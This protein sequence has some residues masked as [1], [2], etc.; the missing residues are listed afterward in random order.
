MNNSIAYK[1]AQLPR[2]ALM[3]G[4]DPHKRTHALVV[5][6]ASGNVLVRF[7]VS[8]DRPGFDTALARCNEW[9]RHTGAAGCVF[10]IEAGA[11]YWRTIAYFLDE[12][13]QLFYLINPFTLK[14]QRDGNDLMR[15]KN[16][17]RDAE[18]A[19]Q[20]LREG[21][22]T[23]TALPRE[24]YAD[25]RTAHGTYQQLVLQ[26][27]QVKL[28]LIT[29]LDGLFPEFMTVFKAVD[30]QTALAV[31]TTC[32]NPATI[33]G[34]S[35]DEFVE[36]ISRTLGGR[37]LAAKKLQCLHQTASGTAGV[38][39]G[40]DAQAQRIE[41]LADRLAFL[42]MQRQ[43]AEDHLLD[44]FYQHSESQYLLS[45]HGLGAVNAAGI[46]AHIGDIRAYSSAKQLPKVAGIIPIESSSAGHMASRTPMSKKGRP[47]FRLILYRAV[48]G[49]VR[50]N[51]SIKHYVTR[52]TT[53]SVAAHPLKKK[54][55]VGAAM[56]KLL[57]I[58]YSLLTKRQMFDPALAAA[59]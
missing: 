1:V 25:L 32:P 51:E 36:C 41:L 16:D 21:K 34:M 38:R 8:T 20:L 49:L 18:M 39:A 7:Q 35:D 22:Y 13:K 57:R 52:L 48:I 9:C 55:A 17:Y 14:R 3:V 11:H 45:I 54:E 12:H 2:G 4:I 5:T 23:W 43:M 27:A 37:R 6:D 46:L 30:G 59:V 53:R 26:V 44:I 56:N 10:G 29:A 15:R 28:Q 42:Q 50:H 31:L 24:R 58:V 47:E 19:A 33:A 40:A